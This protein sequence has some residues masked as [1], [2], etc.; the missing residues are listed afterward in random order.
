VNKHTPG[1]WC[2]SA[3]VHIRADKTVPVL[4]ATVNNSDNLKINGHNWKAN[5][6]LIAA[7]PDML[8]S[9]GTAVSVIQELYHHIEDPKVKEYL[10]TQG[11]KIART[12][13]QATGKM[14]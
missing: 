10:T 1:P 6:L 5:A 13:N 8:E 11:D 9:L 3:E 2:I 7:A 4:L 12:I 14:L